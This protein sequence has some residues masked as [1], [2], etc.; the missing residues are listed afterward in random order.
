MQQYQQLLS[1]VLAYN[2]LDDGSY[3]MRRTRSGDVVSSFDHKLKFN[4]A[5]GFPAVT[6][7]EL[8]LDNIL[9][10]LFMF[11]SGS[12]DRR[13]MQELRFGDF[14]DDRFDIWK[15][16]CLRAAKENPERFNGYNLGEL[17]PEMWMKKRITSSPLLV[18]VIEKFDVDS[19]FEIKFGGIPADNSHELCDKHFQ[20]SLGYDYK[21][22]GKYEAGV[23]KP[24]E[25]KATLLVQFSES[26]Y[27]VR[28]TIQEIK[29][30]RV[31]D[32]YSPTLKGVGRLGDTSRKSWNEHDNRLY[33]LWANMITR[34][35]D[36]NHP[37]YASYGAK[38]VSVSPRWHYFS[39]FKKDVYCL[40]GY[41]SWVGDSTYHL[42]KDYLSGKVYSRN[43]CIFLE[44]SV[45]QRI[46]NVDVHKVDGKLFLNLSEALQYKG[47]KR[48]A[49][50]ESQCR[51]LKAQGS[52]VEKI[53]ERLLPKIFINQIQDLI[54]SLK[55]TPTDRRLLV[56]AWNPEYKEKAVLPACH[57][58][59]QVWVDFD[60]HGHRYLDLK[61]NQRAVDAGLGLPYN[62]SSYAM[63][64]IFLAKL[65]GC[66]PRHL[67]AELGVTEIYENS[68]EQIGTILNRQPF[69]LPSFK[70]PSFKSL[71]DLLT[72]PLY[73]FGL[74]D[75][76]N[77]GIL[78][79]D[80]KVGVEDEGQSP[81]VSEGNTEG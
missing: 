23:K 55:E 10:E 62:I 68:L 67:T 77:H 34:C 40:S 24:K 15:G 59:F 39:E 72:K 9:A 26:G 38:G 52:L 66:Q 27:C 50:Y 47:L 7:K 17:Y 28:K 11:L 57:N 12:C 74:I 73:K 65:T 70:F 51:H 25:V 29:S 60:E 78:K 71:D 81:E 79:I 13:L 30:G 33:R 76:K 18:E 14:K 8:N 21:V 75:Y 19:E 32:P 5:H 53:K 56:D 6:T 61:Y 37:N 80:L 58:M 4:L 42:D 22:I 69:D 35:Y 3:L 36:K 43:T 46:K 49:D 1:N 16:D 48:Q 54:D 63:L 45:N 64:L 20:N 41:Q 2:L 44:E 31:S